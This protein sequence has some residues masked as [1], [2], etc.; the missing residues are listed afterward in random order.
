M[1]TLLDHNCPRINQP[2]NLD[3]PL[4]P[5]QK[6]VIHRMNSLEADPNIQFTHNQAEISI[7]TKVSIL[8]DK[9]GSGKTYDIVGLLSQR[10]NPTPQFFKYS[11]YNSA[12]TLNLKI[13]IPENI[14]Q[15]GNLIIVSHSLVMQWE[16]CIKQ[17]DLTYKLI[18]S[19]KTLEG[20]NLEEDNSDIVLVSSTFINKCKFQCPNFSNTQWDESNYSMITH[21]WNRIIV[22]EPHKIILPAKFVYNAHFIWLICATPKLLFNT[23]GR[24]FTK[25]FGGGVRGLLYLYRIGEALV[26]K[27]DDNYIQETLNL[28]EI[29]EHYHQCLTPPYLQVFRNDIPENVIDLLQAG[30]IGE[31]MKALNCEM[32]TSE[33][34]VK[35]LTHYYKTQLH[36]VNSHINF[37]NSLIISEEDR[38]DRLAPKLEERTRLISKIEG[39]QQRIYQIN[40]SVCPVCIEN[41]TNPTVTSCC[42][43]AF[44]FE[45]IIQSISQNKMCPFCRSTLST[46]SLNPVKPDNDNS[47]DD[48]N[49][50]K[51]KEKTPHYD[52]I[53]TLVNL[54]KDSDDSRN[55]LLFSKHDH[56]FSEIKTAL[57]N[58]HISYELLNGSQAVLK[59]KIARFQEGITKVI[60]LNSENFGSGL[61]LEMATDVIIYH[62]LNNDMREQV[63]GRAQRIGRHQQLDVHYL[64]YE[65]E[66]AFG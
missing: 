28:P 21:Y 62:K 9:V 2:D 35:S 1:I 36:N 51:P 50:D 19:K 20:F 4:Y 29:R 63:I 17:S 55:F 24:L 15:K 33:N 12:P 42:Q 25:L 7:N 45:C 22:D 13:K 3:T 8:A 31:A 11:A 46:A 41:F 26:I 47:N 32:Q 60:L 56:I 64:A 40:D 53:T 61:N 27:N 34:I 54:I 48:L 52:K 43:N 6:T 49:Q 16:T 57:A 66:Y 23:S 18:N 5:Y 65:G 58:D 38:E 14:P 39:I 10:I 59:N 30:S 44:C 37:L